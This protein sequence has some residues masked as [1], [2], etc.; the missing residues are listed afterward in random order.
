MTIKTADRLH[1]TGDDQ[2]DRL[3]ANEPMALLIGF[4]LDQQVPVQ[5]AFSGPKVLLERLG[6]LDAKRLAT[7]DP[8]ELEAAAK[9]PPAIHRFPRAMATRI[10]ELAA[11]IAETYD[12]DASRLWTEAADGADLRRRI[13][14]LPGFGEMKVNGLTAVLVKRLGVRPPGWEDALP[15]YP[16]LGDVDSRQALA[17]YQAKKRA[18]KA[19]LRE[20]SE[21]FKP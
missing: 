14:Q 6:T 1:F 13:A 12:G 11:H 15:K 3:L 10:R 8:A 21:T 17:D 7:I 16:T 2:A 19:S 4:A 5:K 9:G 18:Y 20:R